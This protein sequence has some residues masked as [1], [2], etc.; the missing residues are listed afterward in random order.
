MELWDG[1]YRDGTLAGVT[2]TRGI[3]KLPDGIYHMGIEVL[4]RHTDGDYLLMQRDYRKK[5]HPGM[6]ETS[7]GG[8]V[9]KGEDTITA[10]KR[11]LFEETGLDETG[12][13]LLYR[14][15]TDRSQAIIDEFL[16]ITDKP[17]DSIT[18]QEGETIAYKWVSEEEFIAYI[19]SDS[20]IKTQVGRFSEYFRKIG[21]MK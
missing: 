6:Y 12:F 11:E 18:L 15:V 8:C 16:V 3:N 2:L 1:Y 17:K 14:T 7:M 20:C 5:S 13:T 19:N 9:V 4:V 21:Y 10:V